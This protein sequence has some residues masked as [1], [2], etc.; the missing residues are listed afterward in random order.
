M[1]CHEK[2]I[3]LFIIAVILI[4]NISIAYALTEYP[5]KY[6]ES[7]NLITGKDNSY[8]YNALNQL[9]KVYNQEGTLLEEYF[10][11]ENGERIKKI[12][13][14]GDE[15]ETTYYADS[16]FVRV[17]NSTGTYDTTYYYFNSQLAARKD[18]DGEK[19]YYHPDHLGS[20]NLITNEQ[21][22]VVEETTYMPFGA[23]LTDSNERF[24]YTGK[25]KDSTNLYYYGA[26]Y[27]D[28]FLRRFTQP[29]TIIPNVYDP[30][31][32]N[33]YS[34][35]KNNPYKYVD[36]SGHF[37]FLAPLIYWGISM[38]SSATFISVMTFAAT[39][40]EIASSLIA[41]DIDTV[42]TAKEDPTPLNIGFAALAIMS[43]TPDIPE[44][45][46][47]KSI[48]KDTAK[49][50]RDVIFKGDNVIK[51]PKEAAIN[52]FKGSLGSSDYSFKYHF[53]KHKG[54]LTE[55]EYWDMAN[56]F[57][58]SSKNLEWPGYGI[59]KPLKNGEPGY[60]LKS[61]TGEKGLYTIKGNPVYYIPPK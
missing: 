38:L 61:N 2:I 32:I 9:S 10:Y 53:W 33:R 14:V 21:G 26:R 28:P 22:E 19:F 30:Q 51:T 50:V 3:A 43:Y 18:P 54:G 49:N 24:L 34:Y 35:V 46:I 59:Y 4:S 5:L 41:D 27:Y 52:W 1:G 17:V 6:D 36:P 11:D 12:S 20:T 39:S 16:D 40:P 37:A 45:Q 60:L 15:V 7:G 31:S 58:K 48:V 57:G 8:E 29:D 56:N 47:V 23:E 42:K 25:E 44:K 55:Q 13:H